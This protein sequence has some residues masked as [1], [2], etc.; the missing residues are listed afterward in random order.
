MT[1][2]KLICIAVAGLALALGAVGCGDPVTPGQA[3]GVVKAVAL[4]EHKVTLDHG[5]I[6]G[7]MQAM[8]MEFR[9]APGVSLEDIAPGTEVNFRVEHE[10]GK[11]TVTEIRPAGAAQR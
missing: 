9:V 2:R 5:E 4:E 8:T 7:M 11:Y 1:S 3:H 6:P 10:G